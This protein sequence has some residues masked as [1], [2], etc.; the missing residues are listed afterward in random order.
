MIL[1][2]VLAGCASAPSQRSGPQASNPHYKVGQPYKIGGRW[3][4]PKV[5]RTYDEKGVASWYGDAFHGKLTANGEIF[6]KN[7]LSAAHK[8]LPLP[9]YVE[10]ENLENGRKLVVRV[11]DRGPF[12]DD[13]VIDLSHAAADELGFTQKGLARVRVKYIGEADIKAVA[14][15]SGDKAQ[16]RLAEANARPA[17][18]RVQPAAPAVAANIGA[19]SPRVSDP[20]PMA[21]LIATEVSPQIKPAMPATADLWLEVAAV[22][23]LNKLESLKLN[24]PE[25]G[26][27]SVR[28][29]SGLE[30]RHWLRAG[31]FTDE[32]I[33]LSMLT[34]VQAAGFG[35]ARL[36]RG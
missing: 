31:P 20:D 16:L 29:E 11:N 2:V 14:A 26:P 1:A 21:T 4:V 27:I 34:R 17:R 18:P 13:R 24:L 35:G 15:K 7:R 28:T 9:T 30:P 10:V 6:D 8:T 22:D 5:D 23:D 32:T 19:G 12:V 33:A 3:Y 25:L 36:V